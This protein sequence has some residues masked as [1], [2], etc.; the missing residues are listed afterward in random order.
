MEF[1]GRL[2]A[3]IITNLTISPVSLAD[4]QSYHLQ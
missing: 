4:K 1:F 3:N 2:K